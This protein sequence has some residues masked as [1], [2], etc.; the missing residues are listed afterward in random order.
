MLSLLKTPRV[1]DKEGIRESG[2]EK[3]NRGVDPGV[4][5]P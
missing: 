1:M 4:W 2:R 3:E 5:A